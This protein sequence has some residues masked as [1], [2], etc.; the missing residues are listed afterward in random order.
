M[1]GSMTKITST[2]LCGIFLLSACS[3]DT[4][5]P[6]VDIAQETSAPEE[7]IYR[8]A[9]N[10]PGRSENDRARDAGRKPAEV[11]EFFGI[12]PGMTVLDMYSGGG[13]YTEML[14]HVVGADGRVYA[15]TNQAYAQFVGEEATIRYAD[16]RL[17]NVELLAAENNELSLAEAEMD[18]IMMVLA[19]HDIYYV[20]P[21]SGWPKI[22]G[23]KFLAELFKG[24]KPGGILAVVDHYAAEG[25]PSE[26]GNTLHRI[27]PE[28]VIS[29]V[30]A[31][32]FVLDASSDIL[33]SADDDHRLNM[34]DPEVRGKTDRFV[35]RFRKPG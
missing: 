23:T 8:Q 26:T 20:A 33:R 32:G 15:H 14:S 4:A 11:L 28:I 35:L 3:Q 2:L 16:N 13:Y 21:D 12:G 5:Q 30:V 6:A 22:D 25:S 27:D 31:A 10:H 34:A 1:E 19:Y 7:S 24:T 17:A 18:A 9:A 29:E